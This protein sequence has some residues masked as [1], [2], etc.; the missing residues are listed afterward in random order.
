M[1]KDESEVSVNRLSANDMIVKPEKF[2]IMIVRR[3][4]K[5]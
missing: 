1:K 3:K 4:K 5:S 2:Q